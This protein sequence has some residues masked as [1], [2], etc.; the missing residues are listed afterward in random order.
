MKRSKIENETKRK[1]MEDRSKFYFL[2][3]GDEGSYMPKCQ[4][5]VIVLL[6]FCH[7]INTKAYHL[8]RYNYKPSS[9]FS[10]C[11][12]HMTKLKFNQRKK[13]FFSYFLHHA[14]P[15]LNNLTNERTMHRIDVNFNKSL[16]N[17]LAC[18]SQSFFASEYT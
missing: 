9:P 10:C 2:V 4:K 16:P 6:L 1:A 7:F 8:G 18:R 5:M 11:T 12:P 17:C 15:T 13:I 14:G 3:E